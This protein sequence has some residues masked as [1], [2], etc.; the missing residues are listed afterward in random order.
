MQIFPTQEVDQHAEGG[1]DT[2]RALFLLLRLSH[3]LTNNDHRLH[4]RKQSEKRHGWGYDTGGLA[5]ACLCRSDSAAADDR[6]LS[7]RTSN[8]F[9]LPSDTWNAPVRR[10]SVSTLPP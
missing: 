10:S 2:L 8:G 4:E 1:I 9:V 5:A 3:H 7:S 6:K